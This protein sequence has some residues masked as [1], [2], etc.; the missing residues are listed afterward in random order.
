LSSWRC[1]DFSACD[2]SLQDDA[3]SHSS[4]EQTDKAI[5]GD[6]GLE[7]HELSGQ[8][9]RALA[10]ASSWPVVGKIGTFNCSQED[11][12]VELGTAPGRCFERPSRHD[13]WHRGH[14]AAL[15]RYLV[16]T[17]SALPFT[18]AVRGRI[19]ALPP[20]SV[21]AWGFAN[22]KA[23][24]HPIGLEMMVETMRIELTTSAL[25]TRRSPS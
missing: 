17:T 15:Q 5:A 16:S 20:I 1:W 18:A 25:R 2:R 22:G 7:R 11:R 13:E 14:S 9:V 8:G 12:S 19:R 6:L 10:R 21:G 3:S 4:S 24:G 23:D